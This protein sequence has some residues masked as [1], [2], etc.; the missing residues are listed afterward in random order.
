MGDMRL[1]VG[2]VVGAADLRLRVVTGSVGLDRPVDSAHVSELPDPTAWLRGGE[3]LMTTG[4]RLS[5]VHD[6]VNPSEHARQL[7]QEIWNVTTTTSPRRTE[8]TSWPTSRTSAT[9][10]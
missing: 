1:T 7:P 6:A 9:H 3:L 5:V 4:V 2:D 8:R 10:S